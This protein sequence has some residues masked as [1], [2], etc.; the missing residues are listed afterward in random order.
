[1]K[2]IVAALLAGWLLI[3]LAKAGPMSCDLGHGGRNAV[4]T[5]TRSHPI[6]DTAIYSLQQGQAPRRPFFEGEPDD[7]RGSDLRTQCAKGPKSRAMRVWGDFFS[8]SYPR[9][10]VI[11]REPRTSGFV[12][13]DFAERNAPGWL[14]LGD[15]DRLLV[16][17]PGGRMQTS[18][19]YLVYRFAPG[20]KA[21]DKEKIVDALPDTRGYEVIRFKR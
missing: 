1:M 11:V 19:R 13:L 15:K 4:V 10:F 12:R 17:P 2:P 6:G 21:D 5:I 9:G 7:S 3:P 8:A 20:L 14:Y 18:K 16:F